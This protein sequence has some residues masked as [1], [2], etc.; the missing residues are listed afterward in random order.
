MYLEG[1]FEGRLSFYEADE[2][3]YGCIGPVRFMWKPRD[4]ADC[5]QRSLWIWSHPA[6]YRKIEEQ[7]IQVFKL[8][9]YLPVTIGA[10]DNSPL[11]KKMKMSSNTDA[12]GVED[13]ASEPT[14][15]E[16]FRSDTVQLESLKDKLVRFKLLG[17]MSTAVL[18]NV[19]KTVEDQTR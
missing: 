13:V 2:Y 14:L 10:D 12:G 19:L 5:Q 7:L 15:S 4:S 8:E 17:P 16:V 3:P 9:K 18:A 6:I 1:Q 11:V